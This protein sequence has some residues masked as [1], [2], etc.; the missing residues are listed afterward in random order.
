MCSRVRWRPR[1]TATSAALPW[2]DLAPDG[3]LALLLTQAPPPVDSFEQLERMGAWEK[4]I[5]WAQARQYEE[6]TQFVADR[7]GHSG[8]GS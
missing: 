5:A 8:R 7:R 4:V 2:S 1:T 6:I 3:M